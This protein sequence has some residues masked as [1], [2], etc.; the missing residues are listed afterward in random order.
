ME[1]KEFFQFE[2]IIDVLALSAS[3]EYPYVMDQRPLQIF[4]SFSAETDFR[5]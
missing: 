5:R 3:F 2:I 4:N 1:T